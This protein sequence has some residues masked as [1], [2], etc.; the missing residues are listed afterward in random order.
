MGEDFIAVFVDADED[1]AGNL[2]FGLG[3]CGV[4]CCGVIRRYHV[5]KWRVYFS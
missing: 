3:G 2:R 1:A 5:R 4:D